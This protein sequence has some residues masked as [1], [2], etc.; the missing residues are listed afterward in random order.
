MSFLAIAALVTGACSAEQGGPPMEAAAVAEGP[1]CS[2]ESLR[3]LPDVRITA[4]TEEA[5]PVP[6]CKVVGVIGTETNFEL[7]LPDDWNG[8]FVFGSG[9]GFVGFVINSALGYGV[10]EKG[11][12]TVGN[13]TGH[14]GHPLDASWALNNLERVVSFDLYG[15]IRRYEV[16][17]LT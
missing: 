11:Y 13:D 2:L 17:Q 1:S 10:L 4:V 15:G 14:V 8:K 5:A 3:D 7:L 9:G 12:A 16:E 6:H